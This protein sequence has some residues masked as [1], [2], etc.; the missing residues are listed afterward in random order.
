MVLT[1]AAPQ[2][3][4]DD[5]AGRW[6]TTTANWEIAPLRTWGI[7]QSPPKMAG[8]RPGK[9]STYVLRDHP[10]DPGAGDFPAKLLALFAL[11]GGKGSAVWKSL[12]EGLGW[13]YRQEG[14]AR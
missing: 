2:A 10:I 8:L 3:I 6:R 12:R 11:G 4:G 9:L 7:D 13:S 14:V 5:L 1:I